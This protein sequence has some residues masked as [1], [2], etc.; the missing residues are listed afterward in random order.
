MTEFH[1]SAISY[2]LGEP[3]AVAELGEEIAA[4]VGRPDQGLEYFLVS[5]QEP[6]QLARSVC[7]RTLGKSAGPPDLILYVSENDPRAAESPAWIAHDAGLADVRHLTLSGHGCG[8][9]GPALQVARDALDSGRHERI[10]LVLADCA[11]DGERLMASGLSVFSDGAAACM[12]TR[13]P[14]EAEGCQL[15]VTALSS[16]IRVELGPGQSGQSLLTK[17]ELAEMSVADILR[18]TGRTREEFDYALLPNYRTISQKFLV[19]AL[20]VPMQ[21]LLFG[22]VA[23][24]GHCFSN[25]ILITV[26]RYTTSGRLKPGDRLLACMPGTYSWSMM[27][28]EIAQARYI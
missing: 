10:L 17:V 8:N 19:T 25:D 11:R 16:R 26:D 5:G 23:E 18:D 28:C 9:L 13:E 27:A 21:R 3:H 22:P 14:A 20:G 2:E 6:R 15:L 4:D 7:E 24:L 12:V 1:L